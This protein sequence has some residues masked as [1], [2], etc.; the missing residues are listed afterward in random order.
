MKHDLPKK[1]LFPIA[2]I[3][4][5]VVMA[6]VVHFKAPTERKLASV[7][8]VPEQISVLPAK[9]SFACGMAANLSEDL[10]TMPVDQL[11]KNIAISIIDLETA[12]QTKEDPTRQH[13]IADLKKLAHSE[14]PKTEIQKTFDT[15]CLTAQSVGGGFLRTTGIAMDGL[16]TILTL[17]IQFVWKMGVGIF[18]RKVR[19]TPG[20]QLEEIL[21]SNAPSGSWITVA[22]ETVRVAFFAGSPW[23]AGVYA[24]EAVDLTSQNFCDSQNEKDAREEKFCSRYKKLKADQF[25]VGEFSGKIGVKIG[26]ELLEVVD[27]RKSDDA[28]P[29]ICTKSISRQYSIASRAAERL[30]L[31]LAK[32]LGGRKPPKIT[33]VSPEVHGCIAL[34]VALGE[35]TSAKL[36]DFVD[37]IA[38]TYED[39][40][41]KLPVLA[42]ITTDADL[43]TEVLRS[44]FA[45][46]ANHQSAQ[47]YSNEIIQMILNPSQFS[48]IAGERIVTTAPLFVPAPVA[49]LSSGRDVIAI[50]AP[51]PSQLASF[52]AVKEKRK[53]LTASYKA[54]KTQLK[55]LMKSRDRAE[56][57]A[58][59]SELNFD[60]KAFT[61]VNTA[62]NS[63]FDFQRVSDYQSLSKLVKRGRK[64][65]FGQNKLKLPWEVVDVPDLNVFHELLM[66]QNLRNLIV[67]GHAEENGKMAD[68]RFTELPYTTFSTVSPKLHS[69]IFFSCFS[70]SWISAYN[71]ESIFQTRPS[72]FPGRVLAWLNTGNIIASENGQVQNL[73]NAAPA[74]ALTPFLK[75]ADQLI[76]TEQDKALIALARSAPEAAAISKS[77]TCS[78]HFQG[79]T[80]KNGADLVKL[81]GSWIGTIYPDTLASQEFT[82]PC[83]LVSA[84]ANTVALENGSLLEKS[85]LEL[86]SDVSVTFTDAQSK[87]TPHP[88]SEPHHRADGSVDWMR[89]Q[90]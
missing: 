84:S 37:G 38:T 89:F 73:Q 9:P 42:A 31:L 43:C 62:L 81:N 77:Q 44:Q 26:D 68:M 36:P 20:L 54:M 23:L 30:T 53:N 21:G 88:G 83:E 5:L 80:V 32:E 25:E 56:C 11:R 39:H 61:D 65:I 64:G 46:K 1:P 48:P 90:W 85:S 70:K 58:Q 49:D 6:L 27:F 63:M 2:G 86:V 79:L 87:M 4:I 17:P 72:N 66:D 14:D 75:E 28:D 60:Y 8:P 16:T 34:S 47:A 7:D 13:L 35:T 57:L 22:Y 51:S 18:T 33:I 15:V 71:L 24:L 67:V 40:P 55:Q 29:A 78:A 50:M 52:E 76:S 82:F 45:R 41:P 69:I 19:T 59:Q 10:K 74:I 3:T 12:E